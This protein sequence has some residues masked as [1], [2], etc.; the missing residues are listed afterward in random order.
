MAD[1]HYTDK[2]GGQWLVIEAGGK[3]FGTPDP[4]GGRQYDPQPPDTDITRAEG[5][6]AAL[7]EAYAKE[8]AGELRLVVTATGDSGGIVVLLVLLAVLAMADKSRR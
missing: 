8:H 6:A 2:N 4:T 3:F 1:K 7:I 5:A